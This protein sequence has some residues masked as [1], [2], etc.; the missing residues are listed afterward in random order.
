MVLMW[1]FCSVLFP[2]SCFLSPDHRE[3]PGGRRAP[4]CWCVPRCAAHGRGQVRR[5][6][7][8][9]HCFHT[10]RVVPQSAQRDACPVLSCLVHWLVQC[11]VLFHAVLFGC[12]ATA[13]AVPFG[14]HGVVRLVV[15]CRL[16]FPPHREGVHRGRCRASRSAPLPVSAVH[17][18]QHTHVRTVGRWSEDSG[19]KGKR[20]SVQRMQ[21]PLL[22][23][24][25]APSGDCHCTQGG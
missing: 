22:P 10:A 4:Q 23:T 13:T 19:D 3:R 20:T 2:V 16:S 8:L 5:G 1:L 7:V 15:E 11:D 17:S 25:S 24:L 14:V 21:T 12:P 6:A 18:A 9:A